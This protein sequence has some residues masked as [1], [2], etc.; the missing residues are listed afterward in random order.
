MA[1][2]SP[3]FLFKL[4]LLSRTFMLVAGFDILFFVFFLFFSLCSLFIGSF[5]AFGQYRV[6][7]FFAYA[8]ITHV[9]YILLAL[10]VNSFIGYLAV[11]FYVFLYCLM[12]LAF[13]TL[14]ILVR[15]LLPFLSFTYFSDLKVFRQLPLSFVFFVC[16][17]FFSFAGLP[18]FAGFLI[19]LFILGSVVAEVYVG[20][21]IYLLFIFLINSYLYLRFL[22][23]ALFELPDS[24]D[25]GLFLPFRMCD[26]VVFKEVSFNFDATP[27]LEDMHDRGFAKKYPRFLGLFSPAVF[28]FVCGLILSLLTFVFFVT[29][30]EKKIVR[31]IKKNESGRIP[32][33]NRPIKT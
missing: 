22:T 28:G 4:L 21:V 29:P 1:V 3:A 27:A 17:L 14:F 32:Q 20:L 26:R 19:K 15:Q 11:I 25:M 33:Q 9:G 13:F 2:V 7:R 10:S 6:K 23:V 8:S 18:P 12:L 16:F 24:S 30:H 31:Y 5:G